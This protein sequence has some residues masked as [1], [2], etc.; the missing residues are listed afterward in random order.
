MKYPLK[1]IYFAISYRR[2][3]VACRMSEVFEDS[4]LNRQ[5]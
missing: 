3:R 4:H 2:Q 5:K 1:V